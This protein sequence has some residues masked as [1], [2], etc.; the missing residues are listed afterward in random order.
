MAVKASPVTPAVV[1][2]ALDEDGRSDLDIAQA[3]E[4]D[5]DVLEAWATGDERPSTGQV[6][7]LADLLARPRALFFLPQPPTEAALPTAFRHP[8]GAERDVGVKARRVVRKVRRVQSALSWAMRDLPGVAVPV[9]APNQ[10]PRAI[11]DVVRAW[12]EVPLSSQLAWSD[13]RVALEAWRQAVDRRGL[14]PFAIEIG[15]DDVRGFS[16]W[17][18][19]APTIVYNVSSVS[20]A[21]RIFTIFHEVGH[22]ALRQD[23]ACVEPREGGLLGG[24]VERW[25]ERFAAE[26]LMPHDDVRAFVGG[27]QNPGSIAAVRSVMSRYRVS[28]RAAALRLVEL[29]FASPLL[30]NEVARV[31]QPA[32]PNPDAKPRSAPRHEAR[33]RQYGQRAVSTILEHLPP[34]DALSILRVEVEDVRRMPETVRGVEGF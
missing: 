16:I 19:H 3:L 10:E 9:A 2:W 6:T 5:I 34:Q 27:L 21:A 12:L 7:R 11:A 13:E 33:L 32:P 23:S 28:A 14:F 8:P 31:F 20:P 1:R 25:C 24:E 17:D 18:E 4:V 22:L 30:Y 15:R 26:L 29:K